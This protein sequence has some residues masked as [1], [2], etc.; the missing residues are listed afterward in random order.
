MLHGGV[1]IGVPYWGPLLG[2]LIGV[3]IGGRYWGESDLKQP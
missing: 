1:L 3:L 2:S